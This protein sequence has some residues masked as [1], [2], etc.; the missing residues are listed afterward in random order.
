MRKPTLGELK[1]LV[2]L[3]D[4]FNVCMLTTISQEGHLHSRP[5]ALQEPEEDMPLWLISSTTTSAGRHVAQRRE[6]NI[7]CYRSSDMAWISIA[8]V[9]EI[10]AERERIRRLWKD[11]WKTW[12][13]EG[14]ETPGIAILK[15]QPISVTYWLP[16]QSRAGLL[17]E[18]LKS[19]FTHEYA[20]VGPN[21]TF[22]LGKRDLQ[23]ARRT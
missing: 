16:E 11:G 7:A 13:T 4:D 14:P 20:D 19:R 1:E 15:V 12:F 21:R 9:G 22:D 6:L 10:D 2:E 5:M 3:L 23:A 18:F 17:F 8:G